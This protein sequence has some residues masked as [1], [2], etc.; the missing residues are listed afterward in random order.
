MIPPTCKRCRARGID[1]RSAETRTGLGPK[2]ESPVRE[3]AP[4]A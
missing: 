2:D 1:T 4:K 3:D